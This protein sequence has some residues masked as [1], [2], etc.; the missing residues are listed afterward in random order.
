[1]GHHSLERLVEAAEVRGYEYIIVSDHSQ[2][3]AI[4]NGLTVERLRAQ[5]AEI[6]AL[7]PRHRIRILAGCECDILADG[8]MDFPDDVLAELD[9][10]L[11]AVHSRFKQ[12]RAEMTSRI[13]RALDNPHVRIL[14]HPTG[15]LLGSREPY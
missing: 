3:T 6:R 4:A 9:V 2:S 14:V 8:A 12:P 1:D 7:Q 5:R 15:R 10:V 11:A 13:C